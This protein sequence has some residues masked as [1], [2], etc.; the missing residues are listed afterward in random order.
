LLGVASKDS[1][2]RIIIFASANNG[3]QCERPVMT[4]GGTAG[5]SEA[6]ETAERIPVGSGGRGSRRQERGGQG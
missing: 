2:K 3:R 1:R 6:A 4:A 5:S